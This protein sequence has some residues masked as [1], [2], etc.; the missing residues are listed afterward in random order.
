[1]PEAT[2]HHR[3]YIAA[4]TVRDLR[5]ELR[6]AKGAQFLPEEL[7]PL[8]NSTKHFALVVALVSALA[9]LA[10]CGGVAD[11]AEPT[12]DTTSNLSSGLNQFQPRMRQAKVLLRQ[13]TIVL[14][15]YNGAEPSIVTAQGDIDEGI[16]YD[17]THVSA[18][19]DHQLDDAA[20][21]SAA[22]SLQECAQVADP[23]ARGTCLLH[24]A[25]DR[26]KAATT[27]KGG[28]RVAAMSAI[29]QAVADVSG[30]P[31][32]AAPDL[33]TDHQPGQ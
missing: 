6:R 2:S 3:S 23:T 20:N 18:N 12:A 11:S 13:A 19:E 8:P 22:T 14:G 25:H 1:V 31:A 27:D 26:L 9:P 16:Q 29:D 24:A 7:M 21:V 32:P 5:R 30:V 28:F 10:A 33:Q 4:R 15:Q 17:A